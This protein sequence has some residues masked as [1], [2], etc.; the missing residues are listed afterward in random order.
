MI[1]FK[2]P[3]EFLIPSVCDP[4][5]EF[6]ADLPLDFDLDLELLLLDDLDPMSSSN[7]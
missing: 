1:S 6:D 3:L 7:L 4:D 2:D 5:I